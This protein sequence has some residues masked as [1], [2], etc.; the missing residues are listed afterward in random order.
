MPTSEDYRQ[1]ANRTAQIAIAAL[2]PASQGHYSRSH[3]TTWRSL[4]G[5]VR[6]L[7][8]KS[9]NCKKCSKIPR[10]SEIRPVGLEVCASDG[11]VRRRQQFMTLSAA[12]WQ[13]RCLA[14]W[15]ARDEKMNI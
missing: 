11:R 6:R 8:R 5:S 10:A 4:M 3:W 13:H 7:F 14:G 1:M 12:R 2:P 9:N 15:C